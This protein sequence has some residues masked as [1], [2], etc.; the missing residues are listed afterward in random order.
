MALVP[1]RLVP[2][3]IL[4]ALF[5]LLR[6]VAKSDEIGELLLGVAALSF[7]LDRAWSSRLSVKAWLPTRPVAV[8]TSVIAVAV[9][10]LNLAAFTPFG[11]MASG[12]ERLAARD[13]A[14]FG[15]YEQ[16][17][18]IFDYIYAHPSQLLRDDTRLRHAEVLAEAGELAEARRMLALALDERDGG[19]DAMRGHFLRRT[20]EVYAR[21]GEGTQAEEAFAAALAADERA[22]ESAVEADERAQLLFSLAHTL[23]AQGSLDEAA[24]MASRGLQTAVSAKTRRDIRYWRAQ[25][26]QRTASSDHSSHGSETAPAD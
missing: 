14:S 9:L 15:M 23:S 20:G 11:R 4:P 7:A 24:S 10:G 16:V 18:T 12:L 5:F 1:L 3:C 25:L 6:P 19:A 26:E 8:V 13:Y 21:L 22:L 2:V 17:K